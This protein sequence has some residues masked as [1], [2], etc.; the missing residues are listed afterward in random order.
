MLKMNFFKIYF[1]FFFK[2]IFF[3]NSFHVRVEAGAETTAV[4]TGVE[5]G[6]ISTGPS[7]GKNSK[8]VIVADIASF[9]HRHVKNKHT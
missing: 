2:K 6:A 4:V 9:D 5:A 7:N 1:Y 3:K 8:C